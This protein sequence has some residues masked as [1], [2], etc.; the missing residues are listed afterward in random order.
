MFFIR[1]KATQYHI[2]E[3]QFL[4]FCKKR[5]RT[6]KYLC[7]SFITIARHKQDYN[8]LKYFVGLVWIHCLKQVQSCFV[9]DKGAE[10]NIY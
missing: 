1:I 6:Y 5:N 3:R 10:S 9:H 4:Q 8:N 7:V 2:N